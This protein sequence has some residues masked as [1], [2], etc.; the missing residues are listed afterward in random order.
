MR[1]LAVLLAVHG[2]VDRVEGAFAVVEWRGELTTDV[3]LAALP[4]GIAEGDALIARPCLA[5]GVSLPRSPVRWTITERR[6]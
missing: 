5:G 3:P 1:L 2:V 6:P 4:P